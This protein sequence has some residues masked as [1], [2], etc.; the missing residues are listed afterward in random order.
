MGKG[1]SHKLSSETGKPVAVNTT[2]EI[3]LWSIMIL[4]KTTLCPQ[5]V[6]ETPRGANVLR[7]ISKM[8]PS[9]LSDQWMQTEFQKDQLLLVW[10]LREGWGMEENHYFNTVGLSECCNIIQIK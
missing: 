2:L 1:N 5:F 9:I 8:S 10:M 3:N 7:N 6:H 4:V